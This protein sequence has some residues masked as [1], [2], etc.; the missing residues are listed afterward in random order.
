MIQCID[1]LYIVLEKYGISANEIRS[2]SRRQK[3]VEA[4]QIYCLVS[5]ENTEQTNREIGNPIN[6]DASTV[7]CAATRISEII[8]YYR[9]VNQIYKEISNEIKLEKSV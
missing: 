7:Y 3:L 6:R 4:R 9:E 1:I 2:S 5:R 8:N